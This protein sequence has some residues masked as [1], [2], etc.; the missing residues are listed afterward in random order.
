MG[1]WQNQ[2]IQDQSNP[3]YISAKNEGAKLVGLN[4][5]LLASLQQL[6][7]EY[8]CMMYEDLFA[9]EVRKG[10]IMFLKF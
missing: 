9:D 5:R 2:R 7:M 1:V 10:K 8:G 4:N 6:T 3:F